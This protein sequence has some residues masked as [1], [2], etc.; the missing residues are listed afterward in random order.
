MPDVVRFLLKEG[1]NMAGQTVTLGRF[2]GSNYN[3]R[4]IGEA[5]RLL[6]KS[7]AYRTRLPHDLNGSSRHS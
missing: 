3:A 7:H 1:W 5:F 4:E 2:A 6:E